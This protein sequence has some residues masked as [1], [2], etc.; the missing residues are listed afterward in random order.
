MR[1]HANVSLFVPHAGCPHQCCYCNQKVITGQAG[2]PTDAEI[3]AAVLR[4]AET[5]FGGAKTKEIAFFGGSFTAIPRQEICRMLAAARPFV[6]NGTVDG[7][8]ISTRPDAIDPEIL[9]LL[10]QYGVTAIELGAQSMRDDV[11]S[12]ACRGHTA[13][14]VQQASQQIRAAGFS[15]GLQ[16]ML[17]LPG[18]TDSG[19]LETARAFLE[20]E[21]DTV[22][23]YPTLVLRGT[24]LAA[25]LAAGDYIP[26][27]LEQGVALAARLVPM[28]EEAGVSVIRL[29]LH[30]IELDAF[31]AGPWHPAFAEL[32]E[33]AIYRIALAAAL[34][35]VPAGTYQILVAAGEL[36][37]AI[38]QKKSNLQYFAG[39]G[40][41]L[42]FRE[43]PGLF[44]RQ[45]QVKEAL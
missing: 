40:Y 22:R 28:F 34:R 14:Q 39:L 27:T 35:G 6:Q 32:T 38:G 31:L 23:I 2:L 18:D 36:S 44:P 37:K 10:K 11:L 43:G 45:I 5:N 8:R 3:R 20:L 25:A 26:M 41:A 7:I 17:G 13:W 42:M 15:L 33:N 12:A 16:M 9:Q 21:P 4:G 29:G 30:S 19:A 24:P 1:R